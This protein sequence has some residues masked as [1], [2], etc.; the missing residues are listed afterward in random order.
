MLRLI[1]TALPALALVAAFSL[2]ATPALSLA[3]QSTPDPVVSTESGTPDPVNAPPQVDEERL[4]SLSEVS[5]FFTE[6]QTAQ[7]GF[8]QLDQLRSLSGAPFGAN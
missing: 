1:P 2:I 7:D 3:D 8:D 6:L 5:F 4:F